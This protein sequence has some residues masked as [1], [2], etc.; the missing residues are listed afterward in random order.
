MNHP[1]HEHG[2]VR[3]AK[4]GQPYPLDKRGRFPKSG[5]LSID[6]QDSRAP[7]TSTHAKRTPIYGNSHMMRLAEAAED[8]VSA[9]NGKT[10]LGPEAKQDGRLRLLLSMATADPIRAQ[11]AVIPL[12]VL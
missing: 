1:E 7:L 2:R 4:K 12:Y 9:L 6:P 8:E 5:A 3:S 11:E 10:H